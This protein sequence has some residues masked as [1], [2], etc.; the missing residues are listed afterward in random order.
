MAA[1]GVKRNLGAGPVTTAVRRPGAVQI[2]RTALDPRGIRPGRTGE[3]VVVTLAALESRA[4]PL[5][6]LA[7]LTIAAN[8]DRFN[9]PYHPNSRFE[10]PAHLRRHHSRSNKRW[11]RIAAA[12]ASVRIL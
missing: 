9:A 1:E 5:A 6:A 12:A 4:A 3:I 8:S 11:S 2:G 7:N 10:Q